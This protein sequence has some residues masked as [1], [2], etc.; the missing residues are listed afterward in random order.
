MCSAQEFVENFYLM[1]HDDDDEDQDDEDQDDDD[2][3][4][5]GDNSGNNENVIYEGSSGDDE[6]FDN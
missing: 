6:E 5:E 3:D 4:S 2:D 1:T